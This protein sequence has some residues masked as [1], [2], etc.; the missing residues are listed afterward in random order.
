MIT[1]EHHNPLV[2]D[3]SSKISDEVAR[4]IGGDPVI[5]ENHG[6]LPVGIYNHPSKPLTSSVDESNNC[7]LADPPPPAGEA[8][9]RRE[10]Y[11]GARSG[12]P[13]FSSRRETD[14]MQLNTCDQIDALN[15]LEHVSQAIVCALEKQ[16]A[17]TKWYKLLV[18]WRLKSQLNFWKNALQVVETQL[19]L[20]HW[21]F[22]SYVTIEGVGSHEPHRIDRPERLAEVLCSSNPPTAVSDGY[23]RNFAP[24][25]A[26]LGVHPAEL[27]LRYLKREDP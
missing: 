27:A 14:A 3:G 8:G 16:I 10:V 25:A 4:R 9:S 6:L 22:P 1:G 26:L 18:R 2:V 7:E 20:L 19:I 12:S 11:H 24:L 21:V 17:L 15:V 5:S 23:G 13:S